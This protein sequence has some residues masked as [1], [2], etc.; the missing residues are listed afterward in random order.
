[1]TKDYDPQRILTNNMS[2]TRNIFGGL[3]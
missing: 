2:L 1:M 3:L